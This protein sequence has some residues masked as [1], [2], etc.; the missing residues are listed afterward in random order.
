VILDELN[1]VLADDTLPADE[2]LA[3]LQNRPLTKHICVTGRGA[4]DRLLEIADLVTR[5]DEV[6]HPFNAGFNAQKGVEY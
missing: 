6:K 4:P 3:F 1:I 5:F 2:V